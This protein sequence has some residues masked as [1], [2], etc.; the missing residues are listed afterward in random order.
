MVF[1]IEILIK[2]LASQ[3]QPI[4]NNKLVG[5]Y[6]GGS[7]ANGSF[8][9]ETSDID[10]YVILSTSL[11]QQETET[12]EAMHQ[13]FFSEKHVVCQKNRSILYHVTRSQPI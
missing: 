3:I 10:C 13:C 7:V 2:Q 6:L 8:Y 1:E 5:I 11:S 12:I 9:P 4:L